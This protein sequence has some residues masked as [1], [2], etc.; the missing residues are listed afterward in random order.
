M[1]LPATLPH[2][3]AS[4]DL[5]PDR[6][7]QVEYSIAPQFIQVA[8]NFL[9]DLRIGEADRQGLTIPQNIMKGFV[10]LQEIGRAQCRYPFFLRS[11]G[12]DVFSDD[13]NGSFRLVPLADAGAGG[14]NGLGHLFGYFV[15]HLINMQSG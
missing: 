2:L 14:V 13:G 10:V 6:Q 15:Q 12:S 9:A 3:D 11:V 8:P 7:G 5:F 1:P 4:D